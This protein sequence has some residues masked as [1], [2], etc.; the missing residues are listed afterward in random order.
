MIAP[1]YKRAY[2]FQ[3]GLAVALLPQGEGAQYVLINQQDSVVY[4]FGNSYV[5]SVYESSIYGFI[6]H[7]SQTTKWF[8]LFPSD[9]T[10]ST[11]NGLPRCYSA[12]FRRDYTSY[13]YFF[14]PKQRTLLYFQPDVGFLDS[15]ACDK[16]LEASKH[17][18][19][20]KA[21][22][23]YMIE[24]PNQEQITLQKSPKIKLGHEDC[25]NPFYHRL[26][27]GQFSFWKKDKKL[28]EGYDWIAPVYHSF[29]GKYPVN[30][31]EILIREGDKFGLM[32]AR[33]NLL[34]P[35]IYNE[36]INVYHYMNFDYQPNTENIDIDYCDGDL[37]SF[38]DEVEYYF[39][40]K[41]IRKNPELWT[42]NK[43]QAWG[44]FGSKGKAIYPLQSELPI[45]PFFEES[46]QE[47][48]S[49]KKSGHLFQIKENGKL[50]L[51]NAKGKIRVPPSYDV[52]PLRFVDSQTIIA[53][54]DQKYGLISTENETILPFEF[55]SV[56]A[57]RRHFFW[58][59]KDSLWGL[60]TEGG[61]ALIPHRLTAFEDHLSFITTTRNGKWGILSYK[62]EVWVPFEYDEV[63]YCENWFACMRK[64]DRYGFVA[65]N[66]KAITDFS[67][68]DRAEV[69]K[70]SV[71]PQTTARNYT[72]SFLGTWRIMGKVVN[73][74]DFRRNE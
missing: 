71:P 21:Q 6:E 47:R 9:T 61:T 27:D 43:D 64:G 5:E 59:R 52:F 58:L 60:F 12:C 72:G 25:L 14:D 15:V 1:K 56:L 37:S 22:D 49:N 23:W 35:C 17:I 73:P 69:L 30:F 53:K 10:N 41:F 46:F 55:D 45:V 13:Y 34:S 65:F 19:V 70:R 18:F 29:K 11:V 44:L 8:C 66:G 38:S 20:Q 68:T 54:K 51:I 48:S 3:N 57:A 7:E 31:T 4:H 42:L 32:T 74:K 26:L 67:I 33:G 24:H 40:E 39:G 36:A 62:D 16:V 63:L 28:V 2:N 50:G